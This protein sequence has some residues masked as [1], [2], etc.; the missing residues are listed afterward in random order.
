MIRYTTADRILQEDPLPDQEKLRCAE[1]VA[2]TLAVDHR[3]DDDEA[4]QPQPA[5]DSRPGSEHR[6]ASRSDHRPFVLIVLCAS[7]GLQSK[8]ARQWGGTDVCNVLGM[9][10]TNRRV[11]QHVSGP[12][13]RACWSSSCGE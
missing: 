7:H 4:R 2:E 13:Y 9:T 1:N 3:G 6:T 5:V 12:R 10:E 11:V 8:H